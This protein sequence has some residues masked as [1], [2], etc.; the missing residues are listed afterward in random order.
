MSIKVIVLLNV[1]HE[2]VESEIMTRVTAR[3]HF[4]ELIISRCC[5]LSFNEIINSSE[6]LEF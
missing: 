3:L 6:P 2:T 4:V 1:I 5:H